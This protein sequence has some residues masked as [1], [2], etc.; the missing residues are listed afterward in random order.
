MPLQVVVSI[1]LEGNTLSIDVSNT[2]K[3]VKNIAA[4]G[5]EDEVH[6][7]SLENIKQRLKLMFQEEYGLQLYEENG[8][9]HSKIKIHYQPAKNGRKA[10]KR[11]AAAPSAS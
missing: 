5:Q 9:V 1:T 7:N 2:G 6:G 8:W 3:L 4:D 10:T 11:L